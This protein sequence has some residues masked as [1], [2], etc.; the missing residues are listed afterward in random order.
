[1]NTEKV[2][3]EIGWLKKLSEGLKTLNPEKFAY[4]RFVTKYDYQTDCGTVC[5]AY[6]WMPRFVPESGVKWEH[7]IEA[8]TFGNTRKNIHM[9]KVSSETFS[10]IQAIENVTTQHTHRIRGSHLI[11]FM[12]YGTDSYSFLKDDILFLLNEYKSIKNIDSDLI[13]SDYQKFFGAFRRYNLECILNRIDVSISL[14]EKHVL[15]QNGEQ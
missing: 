15:T 12:F 5:C 10:E 2:N 8:S 7:V 3:E 1:M 11:S 13:I 4:E 14:L 9:S 6:G